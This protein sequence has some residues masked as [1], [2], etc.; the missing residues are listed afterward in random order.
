[1]RRRWVCCNGR[2]AA[3]GGRRAA[4]GGRRAAGGG[5]RAVSGERRAAGGGGGRRA[6]GGGGRERSMAKDRAMDRSGAGEHLAG[7]A[8]YAAPCGLNAAPESESQAF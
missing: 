6:A 8:A 4:R 2:R 5:R 3:G 1:D 7:G